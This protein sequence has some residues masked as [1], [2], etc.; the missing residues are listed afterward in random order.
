[1]SKWSGP[2]IV[3]AG[4]IVFGLVC[5]IFG[6]IK[7]IRK[8]KV[9]LG[10]ENQASGSPWIPVAMGGLLFALGILM[11]NGLLDYVRH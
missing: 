2:G 6:I 1:M 10:K 5:V 3:P 7:V 9:K 4:F 8:E 11:W